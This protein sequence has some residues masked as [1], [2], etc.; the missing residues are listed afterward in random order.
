MT[1]KNS[2]YR[3]VFEFSPS[4]MA[5]FAS[6]GECL[7]ANRAFYIQL[8]F[9]LD[10]DEK[11]ILGL[12]NLFHQPEALQ[13]FRDLMDERPVIRR[14]ETRLKT[15]ENVYNPGIQCVN[16]IDTSI[17]KANIMPKMVVRRL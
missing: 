10:E 5:I 16:Q 14:W 4:P 6:D 15:R 3:H 12:Q 2:I 1:P 9:D 11:P 7:L 13:N 17:G 8:G